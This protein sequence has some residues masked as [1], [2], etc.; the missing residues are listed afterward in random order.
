[1]LAGLFFAAPWLVRNGQ[2]SLGWTT[3]VLSAAAAIA[4]ARL[5]W[6]RARAPRP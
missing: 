1:M 4:F 6:L 3:G 5:L 2:T